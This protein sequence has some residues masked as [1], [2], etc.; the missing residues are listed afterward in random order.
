MEL[1]T[2]R[3]LT[4]AKDI[5]GHKHGVNMPG[6]GSAIL[7]QQVTQPVD[8]NDLRLAACHK[9]T[10]AVWEQRGKCQREQRADAVQVS[11]L[12]DPV[13]LNLTSTS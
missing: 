9:L 1:G 12:N 13:A 2:I 3:D 10:L 4:V 6:K 5:D 8:E 7:H 11:Q